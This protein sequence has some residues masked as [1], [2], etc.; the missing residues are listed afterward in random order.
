MIAMAGTILTA[1]GGSRNVAQVPGQPPVGLGPAWTMPCNVYDTPQEFAATG[2][3]SGSRH[4]MDAIQLAALTNAQNIIRQKMEHFY[5]GFVDSYMLGVGANQGTD[6]ETE[7]RN[8]GRQVIVAM[9]NDARHSCLQWIGPCERGDV[10][11]FMA[12]Q[13]SRE[14]VAQEITNRLSRS[15]H[16]AVRERAAQARGEMLEFFQDLGNSPE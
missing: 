15:E 16:Q 9:V 2:T 8:V 5:Q 3:A 6:F 1:C 13:I 7:V 14:R 12:V 10:Q 4:R 11:A